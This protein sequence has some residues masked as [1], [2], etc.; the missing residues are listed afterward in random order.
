MS[1]LTLFL[2]TIIAQLHVLQNALQTL[3]V[4]LTNH[5]AVREIAHIILV[6]ANHASQIK[7]VAQY[8]LK[9]RE[10]SQLNTLTNSESVVVATL[11]HHGNRNS[12]FMLATA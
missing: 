3:T 8:S 12:L 4:I 9:K 10:P 7:F 6:L 1:F 5:T 2:I 11:C